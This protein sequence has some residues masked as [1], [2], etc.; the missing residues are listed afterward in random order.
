MVLHRVV[1]FSYNRLIC[2]GV[3]GLIAYN[4]LAGR[5]VEIVFAHDEFCILP[6][7]PNL[8]RLSVFM[9]YFSGGKG[10]GSRGR[11]QKEACASRKRFQHDYSYFKR[12][13]P[14]LCAGLRPRAE[15][16]SCHQQ[17]IHH[18]IKS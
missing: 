3:F 15:Y 4:S 17:G 13:I 16:P 1:R 11:N 5:F 12:H 14:D 9:R 2:I 6:S 8:L 18:A 7:G 10:E